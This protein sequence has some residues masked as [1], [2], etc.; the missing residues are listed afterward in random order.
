MTKKRR[1]KKQ[2]AAA[3][4]TFTVSWRPSGSEDELPTGTE[5]EQSEP[6]VKRQS[7]PSST[8]LFKSKPYVKNT[9]NKAEDGNIVPIR[10]EVVK[11]VAL[12]SLI[13]GMEVVIYFAWN[14]R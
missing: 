3:K 10:R 6:A 13:L 1:T 14:L 4:H 12:A 5:N 8:K 11:S 2:K 9:K 7:K